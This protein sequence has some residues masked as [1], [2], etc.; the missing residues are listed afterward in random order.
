MASAA[1]AEQRKIIDAAAK[2]GVKRF[3]PSEYG[4]NTA[5]AEILKVSKFSASKADVTEYLKQT[6]ATNP[7]LTWTSVIVG[8][9]FDWNIKSG[10]LGFGISSGTATIFD[11]GDKRFSTTNLATIGRAVAS[12]LAHPAETANKH[13]YVSSF[14]TTQN[15]I[16]SSLEK[17]TQKT[18]TIKQRTTK[19]AMATGAE[20]LASGDRSGFY[21]MVLGITYGDGYGT[22]FAKDTTDGLSNELLALPK[23]ELDVVIKEIVEGKRP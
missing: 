14:N 2:A 15:E 5:N 22:D 3:L 20:K 1:V 16:L 21:D 11:G 7:G 9:F 12:V 19:E 4:T 23:E 10:S 18:W 6:N 17:A 8:P 13:V